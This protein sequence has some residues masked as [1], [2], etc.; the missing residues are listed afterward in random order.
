L[1]NLQRLKS[2]R[3]LFKNGSLESKYVKI[4]DL[5]EVTGIYYEDGPPSIY[6]NT[7]STHVASAV[8][9]NE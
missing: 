6:N 9:D 7:S 3:L 2:N 5:N 1:K 8:D 4:T